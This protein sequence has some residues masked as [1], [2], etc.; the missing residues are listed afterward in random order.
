MVIHIQPALLEG[1]VIHRSIVEVAGATRSCLT[2]SPIQTIQVADEGLEMVDDSFDPEA[3]Y[4]NAANALLA[5]RFLQQGAIATVHPY[6]CR[7]H[8]QTA[9][10]EKTSLMARE[11]QRESGH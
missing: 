6:R 4:A 9:A 11:N 5:M 10:S 7:T 1:G 8:E 3:F 2:H